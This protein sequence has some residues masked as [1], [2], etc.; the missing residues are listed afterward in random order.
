MGLAVLPARLKGEMTRVREAICAGED[1]SSVPG[2]S[3]H[4]PWVREVL[5]RHPEIGRGAEPARVSAVLKDEIGL[6]FARVLENCGVFKAD[7]AGRAAFHAFVD[8][9]DHW[10]GEGQR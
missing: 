7:E 9:I 2:V 8:A 6:V 10:E 5:M 1:V 4:A 3:D